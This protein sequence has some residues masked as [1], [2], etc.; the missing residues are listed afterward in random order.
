[1]RTFAGAK[2]VEFKQYVHVL[3]YEPERLL[4]CSDDQLME[5]AIK[6]DAAPAG[7]YAAFECADRMHAAKVAR[8]FRVI[9]PDGYMVVSSRWMVYVLAL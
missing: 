1:M 7:Y 2:T 3:P 8:R 4:E 5:M 9:F 6:A